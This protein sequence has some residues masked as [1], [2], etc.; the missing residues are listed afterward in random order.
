[1]EAAICSVFQ[2]LVRYLVRLESYRRKEYE[3]RRGT[4]SAG[5]YAVES[6]KKG[7]EA[8]RLREE[9]ECR[10]GVVPAGLEPDMH[11]RARLLCQRDEEVRNA[12]RGSARVSVDSVWSHKAYAEKMG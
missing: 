6:G 9:K 4:D 10:A 12:G 7:S 8:F 3:H 2:G 1:M 11:Q 5:F